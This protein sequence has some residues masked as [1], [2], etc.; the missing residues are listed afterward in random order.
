MSSENYNKMFVEDSKLLVEICLA[1][2]F[3]FLISL[4]D[5]LFFF[6][7]MIYWISISDIIE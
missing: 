1:F 5:P 3:F 4:F 6:L 2:G 7:V